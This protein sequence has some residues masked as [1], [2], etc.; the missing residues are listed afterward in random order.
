MV[1]ISSVSEGED[2]PAGLGSAGR[3]GC[4]DRAFH[5]TLQQQAVSRG[6]GQ[7]DAERRV[8]WQERNDPSA[9]RGAQGTDSRATTPEKP[10]RPGDPTGRNQQLTKKTICATFAD[11]IQR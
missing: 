10:I 1:G 7:R 5:R 2:Q 6:A 8:L 3:A 4:G 11:D 9:K